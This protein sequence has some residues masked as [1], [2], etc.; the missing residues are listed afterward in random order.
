[1][2]LLLFRW[3]LFL[4][5]LL[6]S[7]LWVAVP[8]VCLC[9]CVCVCVWCDATVCCSLFVVI[10][11][12]CRTCLTGLL[13][14]NDNFQH[15]ICQFPPRS[16]RCSKATWVV[17][18]ALAGRG[19]NPNTCTNT[20]QHKHK[21]KH[22]HKHNQKRDTNT[23]TNTNTN[24]ATGRAHQYPPQ[25]ARI[26]THFRP[27]IPAS[28]LDWSVAEDRRVRT[29]ICPPSAPEFCGCGCVSPTSMVVQSGYT[30]ISTSHAN[31]KRKRNSRAGQLFS[32]RCRLS[33]HAT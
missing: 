8:L 23:N 9:V 2:S 30:A 29:R 6:L 5:F 11:S 28:D 22:K 19:T 21:H 31:N 14:P 24:A 3:L 15:S 17:V 18:L 32:S 12:V 13:A 7:L 1:M 26:K 10:S 33:K 4:L 20:G 16:H 25:T 27:E